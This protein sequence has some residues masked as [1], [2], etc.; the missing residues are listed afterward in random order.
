MKKEL[1]RCQGRLYFPTVLLYYESGTDG[2]VRVRLVC[3]MSFEFDPSRAIYRQIAEEVARQ[4][5]R[6][7][8]APGDRLPPVRV[9]AVRMGVNPNTMARAYVEL[10]GRGLVVSRRGLGSF[11][12]AGSKQIAEEQW[13]LARAAGQR[14]V[15]EIRDLGL[16]AEMMERLRLLIRNDLPT[17]G[18]SGGGHD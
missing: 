6:G 10:E 3:E 2:A 12:C 1:V 11:V 14:F 4:I 5:V 16:D 9:M 8:F 17:N 7:S 18:G 15:R 13:T